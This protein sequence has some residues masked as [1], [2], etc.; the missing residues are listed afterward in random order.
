MSGSAGVGLCAVTAVTIGDFDHLSLERFARREIGDAH[1]GFL[2]ESVTG[3]Q[4]NPTYFVTL[5]RHRMV[6][7][8]K[9]AGETLP[10]AH[11][12][13]REHRVLSALIGSGV[14]VPKPILYCTTSRW[15]V[16]LST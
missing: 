1:G 6:L 5:G 10:S 12:V 2:I 14:P 16:R 3:G 8:K 13:D 4:S 7:R 15:W 9:P 11:A